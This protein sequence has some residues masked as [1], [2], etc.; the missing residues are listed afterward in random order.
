MGWRRDAVLLSHLQPQRRPIVV[1]RNHGDAFQ[2]KRVG[3]RIDGVTVDV[4]LDL[5]RAFVVRYPQYAARLQPGLQRRQVHLKF[6]AIGHEHLNDIKRRGW[7]CDDRY[8]FGQ[9][10]DRR[11]VTAWRVDE[12]QR[13][14]GF[15]QQFLCNGF[16]WHDARLLVYF[17]FDCITVEGTNSN[18][19]TEKW[20]KKMGIDRNDFSYI[21]YFCYLA[22]FHF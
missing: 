1:D 14:A 17:G 21:I 3:I 8:A 19:G 12:E 7:R 22:Y 5:R 9:N 2:P 10:A 13:L 20:P 4:G 15:D 11:S 18:R 16:V 6:A